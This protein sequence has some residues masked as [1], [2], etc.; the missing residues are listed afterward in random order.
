M[1]RALP[2]TPCDAPSESSSS[3]PTS[4]HARVSRLEREITIVDRL[5]LTTFVLLD[6]A[7]PTIQSRRSCGSPSRTSQVTSDRPTAR[8]CRKHERRI[9]ATVPSK[10]RDGVCAISRN[11]TRTP[12]VCRRRKR[13]ASLAATVF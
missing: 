11:G 12:A 10:L 1:R 8:S 9:R 2:G 3:L 7:T 4:F 13:D 6:V 5:A